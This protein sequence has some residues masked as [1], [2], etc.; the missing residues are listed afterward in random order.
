MQYLERSKV[1]EFINLLFETLNSYVVTYGVFGGYEELPFVYSGDIDVWTDKYN[2]D[3]FVIVLKK[4]ANDLGWMIIKPNISQRIYDTKIEGKYYLVYHQP[5]YES[6]H[7]DIWTSI[8]WRGIRYID[9]TKFVKYL[10]KDNKGFYVLDLSVCYSISLLKY[11]LYHGRVKEKHKQKIQM[12]Y[13]KNPLPARDV[14]E[15]PLGSD[16]V[17]WLIRKVQIGAWDDINQNHNTIRR[18][19]IIRSIKTKPISQIV[20]WVKYIYSVVALFTRH[21]GVFIALVGPDGVGK[22]TLIYKLINSPLSD[23]LFKNK[24][25]FH[26]NFPFLPPIRKLAYKLGN[27]S[28]RNQQAR[29][30]PQRTIVPTDLLRSIVR[31]IYY[32]INNI[33]GNFWLSWQK[34]NGGSMIIF[35]RYYYEYFIQTEYKRCPR[36]ILH[37][38]FRLQPKPDLLLVLFNEPETIYSR[39]QELPLKE[40]R[41]QLEQYLILAK[42]DPN[43]YLIDSSMDI[44]TVNELVW[45]RILNILV[46]GKK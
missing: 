3:K 10:Y 38:M 1:E 32:G 12:G 6:I 8:H 46:M 30:I 35:D 18:R 29:D 37:G 4:I 24:F 22:T 17:E 28:Y 2:L 15:E 11:L 16:L 19:I 40:I 33:I 14:L 36:W 13:C 45:K 25:C 41:R 34:S 43:S 20:N 9:D 44:E 21:Y 7:L 26:T 31:P 27:Y 23:K 42:N 39:K 5:P